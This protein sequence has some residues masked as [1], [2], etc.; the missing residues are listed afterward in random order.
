VGEAPLN[1][2]GNLK[3]DYEAH[4]KDYTGVYRR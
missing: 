3:Q 4:N 2:W 1:Y